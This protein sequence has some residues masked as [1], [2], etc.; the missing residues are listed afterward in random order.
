MNEQSAAEREDKKAKLLVLCEENFPALYRTAYRMTNNPSDAEDL[1]QETFLKAFR[2]VHQFDESFNGRGWLFKI[3]TN[4]FIDRYRK[5]QKKPQELEYNEITDVFISRDGKYNEL[6]RFDD[7]ESEFFRKFII[8][9]VQKAI[10]NL[11]EYYRLP[12][13]LTDIEGF[14][15]QDV[16][17]MLDAPIGTV[18]SRLFRG[19]KLLRKHLLSYFNEQ[20]STRESD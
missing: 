13:L 16:A 12:V 19:R 15:Y 2:S 6:N 10:S 4:N 1:V 3:L 18:M 9:D 7:P 11:P 5:A 8:E 14:S 17:V 20:I